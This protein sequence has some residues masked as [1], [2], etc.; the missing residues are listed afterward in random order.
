M[1]LLFFAGGEVGEEE[2][3]V[4]EGFVF[5]KETLCLG[6]GGFHHF[7]VLEGFHRDI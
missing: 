6:A 5:L 2:R 3:V 4:G 7:E 1:N